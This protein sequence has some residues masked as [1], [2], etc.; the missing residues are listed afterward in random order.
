[1]YDLKFDGV[2]FQGEYAVQ[3]KKIKNGKKARGM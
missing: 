3:Y 1:M 2:Q